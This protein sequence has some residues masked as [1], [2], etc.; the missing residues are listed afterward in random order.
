MLID[1]Y[2]DLVPGAESLRVAAQTAMVDAHL[3]TVQPALALARLGARILVHGHCHQKALVGVAGTRG[4][5]ELIPGAQVSVIDSGCC[6]MAGS[7]GYEHYD[8]SMKIGERV[9]L[10]AVRKHDVGPIV[11]PGFSCRHQIA[12]GAGR[13]A[14]H[15]IEL[16]ARQ[17]TEGISRGAAEKRS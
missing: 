9:L 14:L 8:L 6:G 3:A 10:P 4:A 7:F 11:A 16:I 1:D 5:L 12:H 15:P 17:L 13:Q 2:L